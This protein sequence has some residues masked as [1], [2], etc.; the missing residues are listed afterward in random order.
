MYQLY[1]EISSDLWN[2]IVQWVTLYKDI[3]YL[4]ILFVIASILANK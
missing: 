2:I 1:H 4:D 3:L